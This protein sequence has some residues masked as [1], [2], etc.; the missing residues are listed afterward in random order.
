MFFTQCQTQYSFFSKDFFKT[1]FFIEQQLPKPWWKFFSKSETIHI[2]RYWFLTPENLWKIG[3]ACCFG[4]GIYYYFNNKKGKYLMILPNGTAHQAFFS[5]DNLGRSINIDHHHLIKPDQ[6]IAKKTISCSN[7]VT[8]RKEDTLLLEQNL[9]NRIGVAV[10]AKSKQ[11]FDHNKKWKVL[12]SIVLSNDLD[13]TFLKVICV[14]SGTKCVKRNVL[15]LVG[16]SVQ[17]CH[18]EILARRCFVTFL[19]RQLNSILMDSKFQGK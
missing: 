16:S 8:L 11:V 9:A 10:L 18:A 6:T 12:A 2:P 3:L 15:S 4:Y 13:E 1:I 7:D 19:Y 5:D 14:T 17:D